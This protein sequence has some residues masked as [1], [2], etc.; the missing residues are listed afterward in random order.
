MPIEDE[1]ATHT[2]AEQ[3]D[4]HQCKYRA[5][6]EEI[7]KFQ[8]DD[9]KTGQGHLPPA[10]REPNLLALWKSVIRIVN[11]VLHNTDEYGKPLS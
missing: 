10:F 5:A 11:G 1:T 3:E 7:D 9:F 4:D 2:E 8:P 6:L